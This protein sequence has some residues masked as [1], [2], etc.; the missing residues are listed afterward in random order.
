MLGKLKK[1]ITCHRRIAQCRCKSFLKGVVLNR[2]ILSAINDNLVST[3]RGI[4]FNGC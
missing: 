3:D 2:V 4:T 1:T